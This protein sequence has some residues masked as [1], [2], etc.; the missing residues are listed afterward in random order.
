M[1]SPSAGLYG[2]LLE[3]QFTTSHTPPSGRDD[4]E[5]SMSSKLNAMWSAF[6]AN[7]DQTVSGLREALTPAACYAA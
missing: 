2:C 6:T 5:V 4:L 7:F 3:A 1:S